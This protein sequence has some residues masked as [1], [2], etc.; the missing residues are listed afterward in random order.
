MGGRGAWCLLRERMLNDDQFIR[1][2][3]ARGKRRQG[4]SNLKL[5]QAND[6]E[7]LALMDEPARGR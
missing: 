1:Q 7:R 4:E 3:D 5:N 2:S 6:W